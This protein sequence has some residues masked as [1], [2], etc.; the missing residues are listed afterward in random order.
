VIRGNAAPAVAAAASYGEQ[1]AAFLSQ[2]TVLFWIAIGAAATFWISQMNLTAIPG[3][4]R[5]T[6][7]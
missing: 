2:P 4:Q 5:A 3:Y 6:R 7:R 1:F